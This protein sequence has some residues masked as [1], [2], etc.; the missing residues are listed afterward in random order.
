MH[1]TPRSDCRGTFDSCFPQRYP[2]QVPI[3]IP[4]DLPARPVL[5]SENIFVMDEER[6]VH[7]DI[8]PL[9]IVLL[10]LMPLK[11]AT[12]T[13]IAR[14]LSNSPIQVNFTLLTTDSYAPKNT[15]KSHLEA[16]YTTWK[17]I[18][19]RRFDG[20]IITGAPVEMMPFEEVEYWEELRNIFT[21]SRESVFSTF[22]ICWAAQAALY[23]RF[24]IEKIELPQKRF[25]VFPHVRTDVFAPLLRGFDDRFFVP[26]S[27]HTTVPPEAFRNHPEIQIL[28]TDE[29]DGD[30][31]LAMT[32]NGRR[33]YCFNHPEYDTYTLKDE[34]ERDR[35]AGKSTPLPKNYFPGDD[36]TKLPV[37][38]WSGH[39]S[40]LFSNWL[41]YCV[42]QETPYDLG[43]LTESSS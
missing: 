18:R 37:K 42:Y 4:K 20:M 2:S 9:D 31:Y 23:D 22:C 15:P 32:G 1:S 6:A 12:E 3:N 24:G 28:S 35:V 30:V 8:R 39:A 10:N 7:Q 16:F 27:R 29:Q 40:L 13:Q 17:N 5:E 41:N 19:H 25:G 11:V 34:Y 38:N 26:V 36:P 43:R 14:L 21:W 33:I